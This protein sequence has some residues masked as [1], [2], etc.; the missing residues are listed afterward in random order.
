ME[1]NDDI[2][3]RA[4]LQGVLSSALFP[5]AAGAE[6][7]M[8]TSESFR[9]LQDVAPGT[10]GTLGAGT[11][12]SRSRPATGIVLLDEAKQSGSKEE[13]TVSAEMVLD[14]GVVGTVAFDS[15]PNYP[16]TSGMFY[17]MEVKKNR[18]NGE[19]AFI[20]V[21]PLPDGKS[22]DDMSDDFFTGVV[23]N[24][25]GRYGAY[26]APTDIQVLSSEK[27]EGVPRI[28]DFSLS[29]LSPSQMTAPRR[30]LVRAMQPKGSSDV[31]LFIGGASSRNFPKEEAAF[32]KMANT[33]RVATRPTKLK[34]TQKSDFRF[35]D[36]GGL[37]ENAATGANAPVF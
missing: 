5:F 16:L 28:V 17:D 6:E 7:E 33:L 27:G 15:E 12:S 3:R 10:V 36:R 37:T 21:A 24:T 29:V 4:L 13:P 22:I 25:A 19:S 32:R 14:G 8:R 23:C 30:A 18:G 26:G 35:Q 31:V 1:V 11:I 20:M 9:T 34:R 2:S